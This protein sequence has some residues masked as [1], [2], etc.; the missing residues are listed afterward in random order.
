MELIEEIKKDLLSQK[1]VVQMLKALKINELSKVHFSI[2]MYIR[3]KYIW[4]NKINFYVLSNYYKL[5]SADEISSKIIVELYCQIKKTMILSF[6]SQKIIYGNIKIFS[7]NF[8]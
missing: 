1:K 5:Y 8:K 6:Y 4:N 3:N 2:G 7:Q